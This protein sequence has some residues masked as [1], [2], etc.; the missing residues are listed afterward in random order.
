MR[1]FDCPDRATGRRAMRKAWLGLTILVAST[2][3]TAATHHPVGTRASLAVA[4]LL[5]A[6]E[7]MDRQRLNYASDP[8]RFLHNHPSLGRAIAQDMQLR[9]TGELHIQAVNGMLPSTPYLNYVRWRHS[10]NPSRFDHYHPGWG[11][12]IERDAAIRSSM[13]Q[14]LTPTPTPVAVGSVVTTPTAAETISPPIGVPSGN[15]SGSGDLPTSPVGGA[16]TTPSDT[17]NSPPTTTVSSPPPPSAVPEP[18]GLVLLGMGL[19]CGVGMA[20]RR[21]LGRRNG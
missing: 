4:G 18:A 13:A 15:T 12:A 16:T 20:F 21:R 7:A 17:T 11:P 19:A 5:P 8:S 1:L 14:T 2:S 9:L 10:L 6:T 3:A